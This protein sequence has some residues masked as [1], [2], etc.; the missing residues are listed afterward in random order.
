MIILDTHIWIWWITKHEKLTNKNLNL[1]EKYRYQ[2]LGIS[3][4]SCWEIAKLVEKNRLQFQC[5]VE[6]WLNSAMK[7]P[8]IKILDLTLPIILQS[9]KLDGFHQDPA[10]QIIVATAMVYDCPLITQ[11]SKILKYPSVKILSD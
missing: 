4:I 11:D 8:D 6:E 5:S 9:T 3:M 7:Y 10:D 1:I 2:G